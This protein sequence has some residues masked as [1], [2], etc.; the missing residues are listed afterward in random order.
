[1]SPVARVSSD[2]LDLM[3][4]FFS[5]FVWALEPS[6]LD[7]GGLTSYNQDFHSKELHFC[8]HFSTSYI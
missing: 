1:M 2:H 3:D 5:Y 7:N 6:R 8:Y 4:A